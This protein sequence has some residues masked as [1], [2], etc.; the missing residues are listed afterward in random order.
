[1]L[2]IRRVVNEYVELS[3]FVD[4]ACYGALAEFRVAHVARN[5]QTTLSFRLDC[6]TRLLGITLLLGKIH[7]ADVRAFARVEHGHGAADS[8]VAAGNERDATTELSRTAIRRRVILRSRPNLGFDSRLCLVLRGK[9]RFRSSGLL[10]RFHF[11]RRARRAL[12]AACARRA[13]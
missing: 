12:S 8:G 13:P 5:Q 4:D 7:D 10:A 9:G 11:P 1:M 2:L 3:V 6:L